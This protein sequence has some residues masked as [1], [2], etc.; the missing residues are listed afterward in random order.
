VLNKGRRLEMFG[1]EKRVI[2]KARRTNTTAQRTGET[3]KGG[4]A[5]GRIFRGK[6][7][8]SHRKGKARS[9]KEKGKNLKNGGGCMA[10]EVGEGGRIRDQ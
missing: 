10:G 1:G 8:A 2:T 5:F 3:E 9:G 6:K 4:P 7:L